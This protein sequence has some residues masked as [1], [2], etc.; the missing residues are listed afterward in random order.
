MRLRLT[1]HTKLN[2]TLSRP[3]SNAQPA[4]PQPLAGSTFSG[5]HR[6]PGPH[7]CADLLICRQSNRKAHSTQ[8]LCCRRSLSGRSAHQPAQAVPQLDWHYTSLRQGGPGSCQGGRLCL[9]GCKHYPCAIKT[10][11]DVIVLQG[12][13]PDESLDVELA[14]PLFKAQP[15]AAAAPVEQPVRRQNPLGLGDILSVPRFGLGPS[16][17]LPSGTSN[18]PLCQPALG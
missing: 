1:G 6:P 13:R 15:K 12:Q 9:C 5:D 18:T 14:L 2:G 3:D 17:A 10:N 11:I 4:G 16:L 8:G 7:G